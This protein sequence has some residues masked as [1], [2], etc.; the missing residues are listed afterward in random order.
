MGCPGTS[1]D[2]ALLCVAVIVL[3][4][5]IVLLAITVSIRKEIIPYRYCRTIWGCYLAPLKVQPRKS[6]GGLPPALHCPVSVRLRD[7]LSL[8]FPA[9]VP[10]AL[11][12]DV[13][14]VYGRCTGGASRC[15]RG[16]CVRA[17]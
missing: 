9:C 14:P 12:I 6:S 15:G 2:I 10:E 13:R 7:Y 11:S 8:N 1:G 17:V 5:G 4:A 16:C 3:A